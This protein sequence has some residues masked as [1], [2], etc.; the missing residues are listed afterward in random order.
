MIRLELPWRHE[1]SSL[2]EQNRPEGDTTQNSR[3]CE[4]KLQEKLLGEVGCPR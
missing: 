3:S 4:M 1:L 2:S